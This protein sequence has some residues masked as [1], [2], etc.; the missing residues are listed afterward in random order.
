MTPKP[1]VAKAL[2]S[3]LLITVLSGGM[4]Y[5]DAMCNYDDTVQQD[6]YLKKGREAEK[7]GRFLD[8]LLFYRSIDFC[9]NEKESEKALFRIGSRFALRAASKGVHYSGDGIFTNVPDLNCRK[10]ATHSYLVPN[11]YEP[12]APGLC[13]RDSGGTR[14]TLNEK[15]GAFEWYNE[16]G[17]LREADKS[18]LKHL[19]SNPGDLM[20][21][22]TAYFHLDARK[23]LDERIYKPDADLM[24]ELK[25]AAAS[26]VDSILKKEDKDFSKTKAAEKSLDLL[27][28][29][30][31]WASFGEA[32]LKARVF[33]RAEERGDELAFD[34]TPAGLESALLYYR[35]AGK[36]EKS[37][38]VFAMADEAGIAEFKEN[39][40]TAALSFFR[41]SGNKGWMEKIKPF[42]EGKAG[43]GLLKDRN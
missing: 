37:R 42:I 21:F 43:P 2:S 16:T 26:G 27:E 25:R 5:G 20:V 15:A 33:R 22:E 14:L 39:N 13:T 6:E 8:A 3:A 19:A 12:S 24:E 7:A 34:G 30:L 41:I 18:I 31:K 32:P 11:P 1:R 35:F 38:V 10:W 28:S 9:G 36:E 40:Y 29:A 23:S 17:N 4:A